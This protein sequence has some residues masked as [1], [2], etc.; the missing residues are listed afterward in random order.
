MGW[1]HPT[2]P[3]RG[4]L[5]LLWQER[6]GPHRAMRWRVCLGPVRTTLSIPT[7]GGTPRPTPP[8]TPHPPPTRHRQD[9]AA[10]RALPPTAALGQGR[11]NPP[12]SHPAGHPVLATPQHRQHPN[13]PGCRQ[14]RVTPGQHST[15]PHPTMQAH[16]HH[17]PP[18]SPGQRAPPNLNQV[19]HPHSA[20]EVPTALT[21]PHRTNPQEPAQLKEE[22]VSTPGAQG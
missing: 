12:V 8:R 1:P 3:H 18:P 21:R 14:P 11:Q 17:F 13:R 15:E 6:T 5:D 2:T 4:W 22:R 9:S 20:P 19:T 7:A 10:R 16:H